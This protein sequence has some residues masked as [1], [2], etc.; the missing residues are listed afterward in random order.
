MSAPSKK[1]RD[2]R[3]V[4]YLNLSHADM[5]AQCRE[6]LKEVDGTYAGATVLVP[7]A[8]VGAIA[9]WLD[10]SHVNTERDQ[11]PVTEMKHALRIAEAWWRLADFD[12]NGVVARPDQRRA[13]AKT[14]SSDHA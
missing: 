12:G 7:A 3:P 9:Q 14:G 8:F 10:M 5:R 2:A 13:K 11:M 1:L 4:E 6:A